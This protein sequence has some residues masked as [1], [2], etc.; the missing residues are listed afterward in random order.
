M[1]NLIRL[2][3]ELQETNVNPFKVKRIIEYYQKYEMM[4]VPV[5]LSIHGN[6]YVLERG[7]AQY[8]AAL[9]MGLTSIEAMCVDDG[10]VDNIKSETKDEVFKKLDTESSLSI[11][12]ENAFNQI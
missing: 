4:D 6:K 3:K 7:G 1:I 8:K 12:R 5:H 10:D 2:S 9:D 11:V